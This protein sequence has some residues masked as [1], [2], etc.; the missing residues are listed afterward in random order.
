MSCSLP[1]PTQPEDAISS[2]RVQFRQNF[3][4]RATAEEENK[5]E[6]KAGSLLSGVTEGSER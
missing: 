3:K 4:E 1:A 2:R 5:A 6:E